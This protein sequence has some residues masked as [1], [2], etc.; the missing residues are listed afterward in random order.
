MHVTRSAAAQRNLQGD[1]AGRSSATL[2]Y[3]FPCVRI[4]K[5]EEG[6]NRCFIWSN[7]RS[8][9]SSPDLTPPVLTPPILFQHLPLVPSFLF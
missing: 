2:G 5:C 3:G 6:W 4:V 7:T 9:T 1:F 8:N